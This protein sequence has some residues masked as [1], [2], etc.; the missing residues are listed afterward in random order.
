M[1]TC[2]NED[3]TGA[4]LLRE[5][6]AQEYHGLHRMALGILGDPEGAEDAVQDAVVTTLTKP[7]RDTSKLVGWLYAVVRNSAR[8][9][10]RRRKTR[11]AA[12]AR[13]AEEAQ[14]E[15]TD[16]SVAH[17]ELLD[18]V[19]ALIDEL[20]AADRQLL[21]QHYLHDTSLAQIARDRGVP[22][23]TIRAKHKRL[24][25][26]L[27]GRILARTGR[28]PLQLALLLVGSGT[29]IA[30]SPPAERSPRYLR[31]PLAVAGVVG[32]IA[33]CLLL[34]LVAWTS[35]DRLSEVAPP[36]GAGSSSSSDT[37]RSRG[38]ARSV[39]DTEG[40]RN[41]SAQ[42]DAPSGLAGED[43]AAASAL[44]VVRVRG[45]LPEHWRELSEASGVPWTLH[46]RVIDGMRIHERSAEV[47]FEVTSDSIDRDL[48]FDEE[49][50]DPC[51]V[52]LRAEHPDVL[53]VHWTQPHPVHGSRR[54]ELDFP[55]SLEPAAYVAGVVVDESGR[56]QSGVRV[57]S[58][59][60]NAGS[61]RWVLGETARTSSA[62][63]YRIRVPPAREVVIFGD[64]PADGVALA[65]V[66]AGDSGAT[67]ERRLVVPS[68]GTLQVEF[69]GPAAFPWRDL[70]LIVHA[71]QGGRQPEYTRADSGGYWFTKSDA[72]RTNRRFEVGND[73]AVVIAGGLER[74]ATIS[75]FGVGIA[76]GLVDP[77]A[78]RAG[79]HDA[80]ARV[81]V[82]AVAH[83]I[84][85]HV[86]GVRPPDCRIDVPAAHG[87]SNSSTL[88]LDTAGRGVLWMAPGSTSTLRV[89]ARGCSPRELELRAP[90][91][92]ACTP[93]EIELEPHPHARSWRLE[94]SHD[95]HLAQEIIGVGLRPIDWPLP[96]PN[97]TLLARPID[98][99]SAYSI[100]ELPVGRFVASLRLGTPWL[101]GRSA[102]QDVVVEI[103]TTGGDPPPQR[104]HFLRGGR[105]LVGARDRR[106]SWTRR[107]FALLDANEEPTGA[108]LVGGS[109]AGHTTGGT[110]LH[111]DGPSL[112]DRALPPGGYTIVLGYGDRM[113]RVPVE[114][115]T[116]ELR[117]VIVDVSDR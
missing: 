117:T 102:H 81:A 98:G 49:V 25:D 69:D 95:G 66:T 24:L 41:E 64:S 103:D 8:M 96:S 74:D 32:A 37:T 51:E 56:P 105:L 48:V 27:R 21:L 59:V 65:R 40:V 10:L 22:G 110:S 62:G 35:P 3:P 16:A 91:T 53:P 5:I 45:E 50:R 54:I 15:G 88:R 109:A 92:G 85:V 42:P 34:G 17:A 1:S 36:G 44:R 106:G 83:P 55:R 47:S 18:L 11:A 52:V 75:F 4:P 33:L 73:R 108:R 39:A 72:W 71:S 6:L 60:A 7:P 80:E 79:H 77:M 12:I 116:G 84:R 107:R 20:P 82:E 100:D 43:E 63:A 97:Q 30:P 111:E 2:P 67:V 90:R 101:A 28:S 13:I 94:V 112:V 78:I 104:V 76:P 114:L 26:R 23:G 70:Q 19:A 89:E 14:A 86:G 38:A 99:G 115:R 68:A 61:G 9:R 93:I 46:A 31:Q 57:I 58:S 87:N 29:E 113:K